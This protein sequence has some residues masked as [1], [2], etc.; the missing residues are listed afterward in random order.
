MLR[1]SMCIY[2]EWDIFNLDI[3]RAGSITVIYAQY[4]DMLTT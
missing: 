2:A 3:M 4:F 1:S